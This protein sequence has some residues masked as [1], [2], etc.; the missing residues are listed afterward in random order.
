[1]RRKIILS[2]GLFA[3]FFLSFEAARAVS[4]EEAR[5]CSK[6]VKV[7][8]E[9]KFAD[10]L[11]RISWAGDFVCQRIEILHRGRVVYR[12][13]GVGDHFYLGSDDDKAGTDAVRGLT[14]RGQQLVVRR[15]AGGGAHCCSNLLIFDLGSTFKKIADVYGGN[16]EP[17]I[18]DINKDEIAEIS[19]LDDT[20]AGLFSSFATSAKGEVILK[21][22]GGRYVVA[23]EFMKKPLPSRSAFDGQVSTLQRLMREKGPEWPPPEFVQTITDFIY[24]GHEKDAFEFAD[25]V[26]PREVAGRA[27]FLKKYRGYLNGSLYY[28]EFKKRL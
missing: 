21:Y 11:V 7:L 19:V 15:W 25:R 3:A 10:Y 22:S 1:M 23:P 17:E 27:A 20:F 5:L 2:I 13:M 18:V 26:W 14:G 6:G 16:F 12:E 9:R 24:T 8:S 4:K 28:R